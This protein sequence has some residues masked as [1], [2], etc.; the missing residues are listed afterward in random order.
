M[1]KRTNSPYPAVDRVVM[2][3][4][5]VVLVIGTGLFVWADRAHDWRYY[6]AEFKNRV[7]AKFGA[8]KAAAV[9]SGLQQ[10]WVPELQHA[11][12][13]ITC[14]QAVNWVGF[15][16]IRTYVSQDISIP[17]NVLR[18]R[19]SVGYSYFGKAMIRDQQRLLRLEVAASY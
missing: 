9:P 3:L 14:H 1:E 16:G 4:I 13:C 17:G 5:G 10:V 12:R 7:A 19:R 6:Q 2:A 18:R 15:Y 11:D 8:D